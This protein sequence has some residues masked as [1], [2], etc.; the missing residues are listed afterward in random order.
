MTI[1]SLALIISGGV[2]NL[3][4]RFFNGEALFKGKVVDYVDFRLIN[5]AVFNFADCCVVIGTILLVVYLIFYD[6]EKTLNSEE[7]ADE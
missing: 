7:N 4:D 1:T 5:F 3:I 6:N 2:G